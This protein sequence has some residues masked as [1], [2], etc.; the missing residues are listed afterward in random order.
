MENSV[1][2]L[3]SR[4]QVLET[5]LAHKDQEIKNLQNTLNQFMEMANKG[6]PTVR[7]GLSQNVELKMIPESHLVIRGDATVTLTA[8]EYVILDALYKNKD[9][10]CTREELLESF[11]DAPE[12]TARNIDVHVFSLRKKLQKVNM[13]VETIWGVGYKIIT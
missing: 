1:E 11:K 8:R 6:S 4:V 5:L 7:S 9:N 10:A 2:V 12:M 3:K 13:G